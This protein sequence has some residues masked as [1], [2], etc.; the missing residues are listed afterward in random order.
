MKF[1]LLFG[2]QIGQKNTL[3]KE[4]PKTR[5]VPAFFQQLQETFDDGNILV[6]S[7]RSKM[8][9]DYVLFQAKLQ[10]QKSKFIF[11]RLTS[12]LPWKV[13]SMFRGEKEGNMRRKINTGHHLYNLF[14]HCK[15]KT[16]NLGMFFL[17]Q[18]LSNWQRHCYGQ[19]PFAILHI[20]SK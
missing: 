14:H 11:N 19:S 20:C 9:V 2:N 12:C 17:T 1:R 4:S 7:C 3:R 16:K 15:Q 6:F 10:W 5:T 18:S 13:L 8:S